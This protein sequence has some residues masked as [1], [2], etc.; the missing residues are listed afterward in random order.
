MRDPVTKQVE[1]ALIRYNPQIRGMKV[2]KQ[3]NWRPRRSEGETEINGRRGEEQREHLMAR[4][5][6]GI[7][8]I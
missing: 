5:R 8:H 7:R 3:P 4:R 6:N 1:M 2:R